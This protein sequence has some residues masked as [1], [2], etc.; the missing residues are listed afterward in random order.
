M[1]T[2]NTT[3][4]ATPLK[5]TYAIQTGSGTVHSDAPS[6][7]VGAAMV[8]MRDG[9]PRHGDRELVWSWLEE[10]EAKYP[11][12]SVAPHATNISFTPAAA[13]VHRRMTRAAAALAE[14]AG[15]ANNNTTRTHEHADDH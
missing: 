1:T 8:R 5:K 6:S 4:E 2:T 15:H 3:T 7:A 14:R 13:T 9:Q 11:E 10:Q 12:G